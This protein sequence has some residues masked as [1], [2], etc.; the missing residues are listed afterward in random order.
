MSRSCWVGLC[1]TGSLGGSWPRLGGKRVPSGHVLPSA[2]LGVSLALGW[3][4]AMRGAPSPSLTG[5]VS[6]S[7]PSS[8]GGWLAMVERRGPHCG[9]GAL[10]RREELLRAPRPGAGW[11]LPK[12]ES[13]LCRAPVF[14]WRLVGEEVCWGLGK[15]SPCPALQRKRSACTIPLFRC[16]IAKQSSACRER[17]CLAAGMDGQRRSRGLAA[18]PH[19]S[20]FPSS[21][22]NS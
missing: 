17:P 1:W 12:G 7:L 18:F 20:P 15:P 3:V 8:G 16:R 21:P 10:S 9:A 4:R 13:G 6:I 14:G 2:G 19:R 11:T 5:R 22:T